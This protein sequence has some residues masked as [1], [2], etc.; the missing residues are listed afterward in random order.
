MT[1]RGFEPILIE[2]PA[3]E[4]VVAGVQSA[5]REGALPVLSGLRVDDLAAILSLCHAYLGNDSGVTHLAAAS[6]AATV[7]LFGPT[8]P[9]VWGPRGRSVTIIRGDGGS[10][11]AITV[12]HVI[13]A[14]LH[15]DASG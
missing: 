9:A 14:L 6:G 3:D 1:A 11:E 12:E 15:H 2:G 5:L 10:L 13:D 7:A 8:D 4:E